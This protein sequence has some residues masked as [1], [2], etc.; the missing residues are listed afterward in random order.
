MEV[1][2]I[3]GGIALLL[4]GFGVY[5]WKKEAVHLL[6]NFSNDM[7]RIRDRKG[8]A[9]WAGI[10][11]IAIS[12]ILFIEGVLIWRYDGTEYEIVPVVATLP[13]ISLLTVVYLAGGQ[14]YLD[15]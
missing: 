7:D 3:F 13:V 6:S 12:L 1:L 10:F 5:I 2:V 14:R 11:I 15:P 4:A 8:L 9:R